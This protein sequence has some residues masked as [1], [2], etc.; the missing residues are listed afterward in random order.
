MPRTWLLK[1]L[2]RCGRMLLEYSE[3]SGLEKREK[4]VS[5]APKIWR[6]SRRAEREIWK[7]GRSGVDVSASEASSEGGSGVGRVQLKVVKRALSRK[8]MP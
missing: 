3:E 8:T 7:W 1:A 6:V 5:E 4:D 2:G